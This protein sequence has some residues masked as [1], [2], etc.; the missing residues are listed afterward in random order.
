MSRSR[1]TRAV[2]LI[3]LGALAG[4]L[5]APTSG[6]GTRHAIATEVDDGRKY[7]TYLGRKTRE[8]VGQMVESSKRLAHKVIHL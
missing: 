7:V 6:R 2:L 8:E 5:L 4:I 3:A 1:T